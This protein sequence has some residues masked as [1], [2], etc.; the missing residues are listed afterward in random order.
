MST[1]ITL[2]LTA[3]VPYALAAFVGH[4]GAALLFKP[5]P[6]AL[7]A[8]GVWRAGRG[9]GASLVALGLAL[10]AAADAV[11]EVTF[12]GG[13]GVFLPA[14]LLYIAGFTVERPQL[15]LARGLPFALVFGGL[16]SLFITS[17]PEELAAPV[18]VYALTICAMG[19]RAAVRAPGQGLRG[20]LGL[21]GAVIFMLSDSLLAYHRFVA[22]I[23]LDRLWVLGT[24]W[25]GQA[26][27]A[28][29]MGARARR[30]SAGARG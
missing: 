7:L 23:P 8:L 9:K 3:V 2:A 29:S 4:E 21:L 20:R 28:A 22:E 6:V 5:A 27:I 16:G 24:Y 30:A 12:L 10:S 25:T 18:A 11:I 26:L 17:A 13:I 19:W 14:H 1:W 15:G